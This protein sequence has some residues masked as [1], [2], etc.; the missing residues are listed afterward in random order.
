MGASWPWNLSTV[1]TRAPSG[2]LSRVAEQDEARGG[3]A[4]RE[5][6]GQTHLSRLVDDEDVDRA[7]HLLARPQ[8]RGAGGEV[9]LAGGE[10]LGDLLVGGGLDDALVRATVGVVG[11]LHAADIDRHALRR[12]SPFTPGRTALV[13]QTADGFR[14]PSPGHVGPVVGRLADRAE[15]VRDHLVAVGGD[16]DPLPTGEQVEDHPRARVGLAAAGRTLDGE[17]RAVEP[18]SE[19]PDGVERR[20]AGGDEARP[21][22]PTGRGSRSLL[23]AD[24]WPVGPTVR[25]I[26][27]GIGLT[28]PMTGS[29]LIGRRPEARRHPPQQVEGRPSLAV[30]R[31]RLVYPKQEVGIA[32]P[33]AVRILQAPLVDDVGPAPHRVPRAGGGRGRIPVR[34][35]RV[36]RR[37]GRHR[38]PFR[39][40]P[41]Q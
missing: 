12:R 31:A 40:E 22:R 1:P 3:L 21:V 37:H 7:G 15:Q 16:S 8:P 38:A 32:A 30:R 6:V 20:L 33:P 19:P 11:L 13:G 9:G 41:L 2:K 10:R 5:G 26:G 27:A 28:R 35:R 39:R 36:G 24:R 14:F 17:H 29:Q 23:P 34:E 4:D 25:L 18:R